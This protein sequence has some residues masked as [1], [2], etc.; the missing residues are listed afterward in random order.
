VRDERGEREMVRNREPQPYPQ[1]KIFI[2]IS[3]IK[4]DFSVDYAKYF[5]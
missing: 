1:S 5:K 4:F 2:A 3:T